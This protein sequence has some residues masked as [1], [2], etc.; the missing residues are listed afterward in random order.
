MVEVFQLDPGYHA[1]AQ[2]V[3]ANPV[4][5]VF[6]VGQAGHSDG[7][8]HWIVR[9]SATGAAGTWQLHDDFRL[10]NPA[11]PAPASL[12]LLNGETLEKVMATNPGEY[13]KGLAIVSSADTLYA[14]G[15]TM[16]GTGH[17]IIRKL[18]LPRASEQ[19][20]KAH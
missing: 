18:E 10:R 5:G 6:V 17:A 20:V 3:A 16:A 14:G 11:S 12:R 8:I 4:G 1:V 9:Q 15:S 19:A 13:S 2:S 7:G